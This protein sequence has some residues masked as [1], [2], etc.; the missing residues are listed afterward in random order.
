[1]IKSISIA[2][3]ELSSVTAACTVQKNSKKESVWAFLNFSALDLN[4]SE[5]LLPFDRT[6]T[7]TTRMPEFYP[8]FTSSNS[9]GFFIFKNKSKLRAK[10]PAYSAKLCNIKPSSSVTLISYCI[11]AE[12]TSGGN[13]V[14]WNDGMPGTVANVILPTGSLRYFIVSDT[15]VIK[16]M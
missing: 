16:C 12:S 14:K 15:T 13:V 2:L 6:A 3:Q 8:G 1:M 11:C 9:T 10:T 4:N 5:K 7:C